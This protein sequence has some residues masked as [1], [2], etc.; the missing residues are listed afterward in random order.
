MLVELDSLGGDNKNVFILSA[1][2]HPWDVDTA[3]RRPGRF[4]RTVLVLPPDENARASI[5]QYHLKQKPVEAID[6]DQL[7]IKSAQFSGADLAHLCETAVE[8]AMEDSLTSGIPRPIQPQDF[9]RA[10]QEVKPS[11]KPWFETARNYAMFA[12]EGGVYDEL[13]NYIQTNKL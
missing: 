3:L 12:N 10:L 9:S 7:A 2:N 8:Y 4:D 1:T 11:T 5:L 6:L 13:L